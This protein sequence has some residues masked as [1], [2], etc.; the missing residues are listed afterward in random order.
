MKLKTKRDLSYIDP[1]TVEFFQKNGTSS[2]CIILLTKGRTDGQTNSREFNTF[3]VEVTI[4]KLYISCNRVCLTS[5][6]R[7]TVTVHY[8]LSARVVTPKTLHKTNPLFK[9]TQHNFVEHWSVI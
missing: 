2:I 3:F 1:L 4:N 6:N 7:A 5:N 9:Y 8:R